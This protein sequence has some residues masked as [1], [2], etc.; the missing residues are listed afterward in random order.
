[1]GKGKARMELC[2]GLMVWQQKTHIREKFLSATF[3]L[4]DLGQVRL[5]SRPHI[6]TI[7]III[8]ASM[9]NVNDSMRSAGSNVKNLNTRHRSSY[10][11]ESE[12]PES[13]AR[14]RMNDKISS[15]SYKNPY[16]LS[17]VTNKGNFSNQKRRGKEPPPKHDPSS[18]IPE[19]FFTHIIIQ[20][21]W[22]YGVCLG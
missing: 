22:H 1:M 7:K 2:K 16:S 9:E 17:I 10:F 18:V 14:Y 19:P 21:A 4:G 11:E 13:E 3:R 15:L 20:H 12:F 6:C 8:S 5:N